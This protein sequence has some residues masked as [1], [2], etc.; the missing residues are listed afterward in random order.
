MLRRIV[1]YYEYGMALENLE[2]L[3]LQ[4]STD[5]LAAID[6]IIDDREEFTL[7]PASLTKEENQVAANFELVSSGGE[8][9]LAWTMALA[10]VEFGAIVAGFTS[11][12]NP[13]GF[14]ESANYGRSETN[15]LLYESALAHYNDLNFDMDFRVFANPRK[16]IKGADVEA[17]VKQGLGMGRRLRMAREM[18]L[19]VVRQQ[20]ANQNNVSD[21]RYGT[22]NQMEGMIV[23]MD[24][25][26]Y[27]VR[28]RL[29]GVLNTWTT[30]TSTNVTERLGGEFVNAC[31]ALL[32]AESAE[33]RAGTATVSPGRK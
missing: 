2:R 14:L 24:K 25:A 27:G 16:A 6:E 9:S 10:R 32:A 22:P 20:A 26:Q 17:V 13:M 30:S 12:A 15:R 1:G 19:P 33:L 4:C 31:G 3:V 29:S 8:R 11:H 5:E 28:K 7:Y 18:L 21:S 23:D